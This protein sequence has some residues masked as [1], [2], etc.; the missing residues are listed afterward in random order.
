MTI[1]WL[2]PAAL[3]GL[4]LLAIPIA[5]H[6]VA[7]TPV[8]RVVVPSLRLVDR[9]VPRLRRRR[10]VRDLA[11]LALRLGALAAAA[12]ASAGP[13]LVT[14]AQQNA[15]SSTTIRAIV[16]DSGSAG[17]A[18]VAGAAAVAEEQRTADASALFA[19][20]PLDA[21]LPQA[22]AWLEQQPPGRREVVFIG[23]GR[24]GTLDRRIAE[25]I[26]IDV[27][28]RVRPVSDDVVPMRRLWRGAGAQ[29]VMTTADLTVRLDDGRATMA[30]A[31]AEAPAIPVVVAA[32]PGELPAVRAIFDA[33]VADGVLLRP[34][35][36]WQPLRIEWAGAPAA[37]RDVALGPVTQ[38]D[39]LR[40]LPVAALSTVEAGRSTPAPW[41]A[42]SR[43]L[44]AARAG[45]T[46]VIRAETRPEP[47]EVERLVRA[48]LVVSAGRPSWASGY[49]AWGDP[50]AERP[51]SG[52]GLERLSNA[53]VRH[54]RW[55]WLVALGFLAA[56]STLRRRRD[57]MAVHASDPAAAGGGS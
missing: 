9:Q 39:R 14:G 41:I 37:D 54:G 57:R 46:I 5:I 25:A 43:T 11:L 23:E 50:S 19:A 55:A 20:D 16:S 34:V 3:A 7:R 21:A 1:H 44:S 48:A 40:L 29:G 38:D 10:H 56:E 8:R 35:E 2:T 26:P 42:L 36:T 31:S 45:S 6:L 18:S 15:W 49:G 13:L 28:V 27:G 17:A 32:S 47:G 22:V 53:E 12:I 52:V 30:M 4:V 51:A 33:A 24:P